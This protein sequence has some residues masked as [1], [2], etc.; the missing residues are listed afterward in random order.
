MAVA[1]ED[2]LAHHYEA[3]GPFVLDR[4]GN[5]LAPNALNEFWAQRVLDSVEGLCGAVGVYVIAV[6]SESRELKPWY[7]GRTDKQGFKKRFTQKHL[8]FREVLDAEKHGQLVIYL[9]AMKAPGGRKFRKTTRTKIAAN[10]WLESMLIGSSLHL[11]KKLINASKTKYLKTMIVDG[12]LND[13]KS[14]Q[15]AAGKSLKDMLQVS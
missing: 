11:N 14:K 4:Q 2:I 10:D 12:Y 9:L 1:K 8:H 15:T 5:K 6:Q 7:V 3:F 13:A